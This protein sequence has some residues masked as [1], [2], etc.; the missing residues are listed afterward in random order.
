M[1][2]NPMDRS[3]NFLPSTSVIQAPFAKSI[4]GG[5]PVAAFG[6]KKEIMDTIT[7]GQMTHFGTFNGNPQ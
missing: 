6:G 5:V 2:P 4:G 7:T 3:N 1:A